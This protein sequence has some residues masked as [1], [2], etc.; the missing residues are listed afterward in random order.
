MDLDEPQR[1]WRAEPLE[2]PAEAP[3]QEP[4]ETEPEKVPA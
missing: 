3:V 4:A 2:E 1:I